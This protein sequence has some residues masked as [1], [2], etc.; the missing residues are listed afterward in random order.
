[1]TSASQA[2]VLIA[3]F[4]WANFSA[5]TRQHSSRE[6]FD[7]LD[8]FYRLSEKLIHSAHG[9]IHKGFTIT[10][11][12]FRCLSAESRKH[13]KKYTPPIVYRMSS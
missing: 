11:Q 1:M 6:T 5:F 4:D 8:E 13:F 2:E 3:C 12:A 7:A 10:P 9:R